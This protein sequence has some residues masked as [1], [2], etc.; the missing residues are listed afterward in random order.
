MRGGK[1]YGFEFKFQDAPRSTKAMHMVIA[2]LKLDRL[3]VVYPGTRQYALG[4]GI[5]AMPLRRIP[6]TL[7]EEA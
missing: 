1:R 3:F 4:E 6:E 2:A 7:Q 5:E